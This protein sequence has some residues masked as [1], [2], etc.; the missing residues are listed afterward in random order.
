MKPN[1][2]KE[3]IC[4]GEG[5]EREESCKQSKLLNSCWT[6]ILKEDLLITWRAGAQG[7]DGNKGV[8]LL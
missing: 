1:E 5:K 2:E 3:I 7:Q 8:L 6:T 4:S